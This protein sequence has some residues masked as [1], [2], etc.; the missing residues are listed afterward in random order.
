MFKVF[1]DTDRFIFYQQIFQRILNDN[2]VHD[3]FIHITV[4]LFSLVM[5]NCCNFLEFFTRRFPIELCS[6]NLLAS[7]FI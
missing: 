3:S 7:T 2:R 5:R 1:V 6:Q 4:V